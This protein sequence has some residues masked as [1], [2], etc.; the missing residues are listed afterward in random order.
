MGLEQMIM[1]LSLLL[2]VAALIVPHMRLEALRKLP[3]YRKA[4]MRNRESLRILED[5][6]EE[7]M[8]SVNTLKEQHNKIRDEVDPFMNLDMGKFDLTSGLLETQDFEGTNKW[9]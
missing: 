5:K 8:I 2:A 3:S 1:G 4:I 6:L 9:S 7:I